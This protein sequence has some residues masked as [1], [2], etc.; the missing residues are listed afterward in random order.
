MIINFRARKIS[1][2]MRKLTQTLTLIIIKK[3]FFVVSRLTQHNFGIQR[4]AK[5]IL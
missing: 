2:D 4:M 1:R 5:S 3:H